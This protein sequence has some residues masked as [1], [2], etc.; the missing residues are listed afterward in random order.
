[1]PI[2]R[3]LFDRE[4]DPTDLRVIE[5]LNGH[6]DE[7]YSYEELASGLGLS[8]MDLHGRLSFSFRLTS[9]A[10]RGF[11][12]SKSFSGQTYYAAARSADG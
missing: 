2:G 4:I 6:R 11:I 5:F 8:E 1:M 10:S 7:A 9:L 3:D 12:T